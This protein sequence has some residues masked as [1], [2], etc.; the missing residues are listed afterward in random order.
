MTENFDEPQLKKMT[1]LLREHY[2][3]GG[4]KMAQRVKLL[5]HRIIK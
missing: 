4:H 2:Y 5:K 1:D 3:F